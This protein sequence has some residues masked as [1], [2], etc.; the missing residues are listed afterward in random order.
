MLTRCRRQLNWAP[1]STPINWARPSTPRPPFHKLK[2]LRFASG[3]YQSRENAKGR[4][5]SKEKVE[6]E[7]NHMRQGAGTP[8]PRNPEAV[9]R[10]AE[11][12]NKQ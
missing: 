9:P 7:G 6:Q 11:F 4:T 10:A 1:P 8:Y 5:N 12:F 3:N 2:T